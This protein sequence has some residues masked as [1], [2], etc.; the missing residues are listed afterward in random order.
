[1]NGLGV[2]QLIE[3]VFWRQDSAIGIERYKGVDVVG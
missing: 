2:I 1:M 3:E